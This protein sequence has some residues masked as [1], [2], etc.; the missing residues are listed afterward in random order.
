MRGKGINYDTGT[1]PLVRTASNTPVFDSGAVRRDMRVIADELHCNAV[2]ITGRDPERMAVA[3]RH[4][5]DAGLEVWFAPFLCE[6]TREEMRPVFAGC[7]R[8][9]EELRGHGAA[10]VFVAG[11][12]L[13][14]FARGF[15]PGD[16]LFAR[17]A[18]LMLGDTRGRDHVAA[19]LNAY[20]ADVRTLVRAE[21]GGP[22][23]YAALPYEGVDWD[24][25]DFVGSDAYRTS[26]NA[27]R[28]AEEVR[29]LHAYGKPVAVTEFGCCTYPGAGAR[30]GSGWM[31]F[32]GPPYEG[33]LD[34]AYERDEEEQARYLR[35]VLAVYEAEGV[36]SAFWFTFACRQFPG[37]LDVAS[38]GVVRVGDDGR[39][40][41]KAAFH[42]LAGAYAQI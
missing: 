6:L 13:S 3:A 41:R 21:F 22:V 28:F 30:G 10:V 2:R 42:A 16:D 29:K 8:R 1:W 32:D 37:E 39:W 38:Y 23:T 35:E 12:E 11:A 5:A 24:G 36:D 7:A 9:A 27:E 18:P 34:G 33:R 17:I 14:I 4:A 15:L 31:I 25:F 40:E 26:H 19:P 20:L